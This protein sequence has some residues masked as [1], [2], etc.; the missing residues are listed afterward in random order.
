M[1]AG[2]FCDQPG[3]A[4]AVLEGAI[5]ALIEAAVRRALGVEGLI[6]QPK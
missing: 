3:E 2:H 1:L 6:P 4:S 5:A